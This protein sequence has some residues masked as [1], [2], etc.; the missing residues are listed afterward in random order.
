MK[1]VVLTTETP[2]HN[3]FVQQISKQHDLA[4]IVVAT[5]SLKL[6]FDTSHPFEKQ[7]EDYERETLLNN[8]PVSL[9]D[10]SETFTTESV[11]DSS[12]YT[13][14][15]KIK[16]DVLVTFGTGLV[17]KHI[18]EVCPNG[19]VNL[20]GGDP[21]EYRGLDTHLWAIYHKDFSGLV[22][23]LHHLNEKLDD[24]DI[25]QQGRIDI[26]KD[27][28]IHEIRRYNTEICVD[29]TI[30]A[31]DAFRRLSHFVSRPQRKCGRYYSFMPAVLKEICC[32]N[33]KKYVETL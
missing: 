12:A 32:N 5:R 25:I 22:V 29:L 21:E 6:R 18:I 19:F 28:K 2:H 31:L 27:M 4:G 10:F 11:N 26:K 17:R 30:N 3:Y 7:R 23:T 15:Q 8:R 20:H 9:S 1:I 24:G 13:Y 33:F 14:L 16:P